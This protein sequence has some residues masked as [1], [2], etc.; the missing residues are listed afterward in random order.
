MG[1]GVL[2]RISEALQRWLASVEA[3]LAPRRGRA[4]VLRLGTTFVCGRTASHMFVYWEHCAAHTLGSTTHFERFAL[5]AEDKLR[6]LSVDMIRI[7]RSDSGIASG[8]VG[9]NQVESLT[10]SERS[11]GR[12]VGADVAFGDAGGC[13]L[14]CAKPRKSSPKAS[15]RRSRICAVTRLAEEHAKTKEKNVQRTV[16]SQQRDG[17]VR[18]K[19]Y[20]SPE[21][22]R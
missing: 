21:G 9:V 22:V 13:D 5:S 12:C 3:D 2:A 11:S 1:E 4:G 17:D 6:G 19:A 18:G 16:G 10:E 7:C 20:K 14:C 8:G 15:T